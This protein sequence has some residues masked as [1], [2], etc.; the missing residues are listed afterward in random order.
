MSR[1]LECMSVVELLTRYSNQKRL[2]KTFRSLTDVD[3]DQRLPELP[4]PPNTSRK[5]TDQEVSDMIEAYQS[6][7][8]VR[9]VATQFG[10]HRTT[11][12]TALKGKGVKLRFHET[13][14]VDLKRAEQLLA[15]GLSLTDVA[16]QLCIGRTTLIRA[17][18]EAKRSAGG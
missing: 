10:F 1:A 14:D 7:L 6:G 18:R 12:S 2:T 3:L 5:P 11:V 9:D 15:T 13:V 16:A 4:P 17:R 8:R